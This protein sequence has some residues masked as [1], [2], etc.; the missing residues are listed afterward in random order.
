MITTGFAQTLNKKMRLE[1]IDYMF[2]ATSA[3]VK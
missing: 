2:K 3:T 1:Q